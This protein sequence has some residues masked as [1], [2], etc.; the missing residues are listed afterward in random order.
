MKV[1]TGVLNTFLTISCFTGLGLSI[2]AYYIGLNLEVNKNYQPLCDINE[3][4]SCT[5]PF[6]SKYAKGLGLFTEDSIF[7][8]SNSL[9]GIFFYSLLTILAQ[10]STRFTTSISFVLIALSNFCSLWF[11]Y[12]LYYVLY[13]L[14]MVC[15]GTYLVN[16]FNLILVH[17]KMRN[18]MDHILDESRRKKKKEKH[19]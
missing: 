14:C 2:Y 19:N 4:I 8:K 3:R 13:D 5:K 16:F 7:Y 1:K 17:F 9:F 10:S 6:K 11:A 12:I 15:V 18:T